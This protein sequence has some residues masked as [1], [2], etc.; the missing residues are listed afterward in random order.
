MNA[1]LLICLPCLC[2]KRPISHVINLF[3]VPYIIWQ[4]NKT[5]KEIGTGKA[6]E[7]HMKVVA[8]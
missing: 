1:Y 3:T 5:E 4:H 8:R 2:N 7:E 6:P